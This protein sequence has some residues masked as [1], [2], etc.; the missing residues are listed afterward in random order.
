VNKKLGGLLT[1]LGGRLIIFQNYIYWVLGD[2]P[3]H[4]NSIFTAYPKESIFKF[5]WPIFAPPTYVPENKKKKNSM[6]LDN[7]SLLKC[8]I[9][10][11]FFSYMIQT[12]VNSRF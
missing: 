5:F 7:F 12:V 3:P 8:L 11:I 2:S 10:K 1:Y 4:Q 9:K 6:L